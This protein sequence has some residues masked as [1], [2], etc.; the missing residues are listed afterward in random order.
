M[1]LNFVE[2]KMT[3]VGKLSSAL[4][5]QKNFEKSFEKACRIQKVYLPLSKQKDTPN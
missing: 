2:Q 3:L 5:L 4:K 1:I